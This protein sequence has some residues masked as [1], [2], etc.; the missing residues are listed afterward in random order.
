M[1]HTGSAPPPEDP[2]PG[3]PELFGALPVAVLLVDPTD[4]VAQANALAEQLLNR[5]ERLMVG[6]ALA[7]LLR[8]PRERPAALG[9]DLAVFDAEVAT[10]GGIL[11]V[12]FTE[13]HVA[14]HPG[15]R[16]IT[17][18]G[19]ASRHLPPGPD[20]A[21]AAVGAAAML[22]HEIKNP[23]SGIRGAAQLIG[24]HALTDLIVAEVD[25][26]AALID[27][28]QDFT[29]TRPLELGPENIYPL[30]AHVRE[31]AA[32]GFA[33]GLPLETR[34]DPSLPPALVN[35]DA[36]TQVLLNLVKNAAEALE[37]EPEPLLLI[38][39]AYRHGVARTGERG[40]R[41]AL[42]I[43]ICVVDNGPGPP[44]ELAGQ[45]FQPFVS[46][47]RR[48]PGL[49]LALVDKLVRDMGSLVQFAREGGRTV[50]RLL[51]PRAG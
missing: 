49:G 37:N 4:R 15:W 35:R 30:L 25:R 39:T 51:L 32:A 9:Q 31:V 50:F 38:T 26:V 36:F 27:R 44:P 43:E 21:R 18:H 24:A 3:W 7:D 13:S 19:A 23:L 5:S 22:A 8:S 29:D 34:Y 16:A 41:V 6:R 20:G 28:M 10:Y 14:G 42:P 17:F 48:G 40:E 1:P 47:R 45:L 11:R 12:D 33:R 2:P 46:G